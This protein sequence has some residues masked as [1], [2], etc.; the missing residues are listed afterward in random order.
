MRKSCSIVMQCEDFLRQLPAAATAATTVASAHVA[1]L[2]DVHVNVASLAL[3]HFA[4]FATAKLIQLLCT[5]NQHLTTLYVCVCVC[6]CVC[7][8]P[9]CGCCLRVLTTQRQS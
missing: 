7:V 2:T 9:V 4:P 8:A 3:A 6:V 1:S 5:H